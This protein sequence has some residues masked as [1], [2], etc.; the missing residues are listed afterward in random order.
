MIQIAHVILRSTCVQDANL[1]AVRFD[2]LFQIHVVK[3]GF[4]YHGRLIHLVHSQDFNHTVAQVHKAQNEEV[5]HMYS[6]SPHPAQP[7]ADILT[8]EWASLCVHLEN[9][10]PLFCPIHMD[11]LNV[12][13]DGLP[14]FVDLL[15][16]DNYQSQRKGQ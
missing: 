14:Q 3:E 4:E 15:G 8:S 9:L 6:R 11:L 7:G 10:N 1:L 16:I 5:I 13:A 12:V 2:E